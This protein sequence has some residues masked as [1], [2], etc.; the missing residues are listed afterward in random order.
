[1]YDKV[2]SYILL[3]GLFELVSLLL[4]HDCIE[5]KPKLQI[6][7]GVWKPYSWQISKGK[8]KGSKG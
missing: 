7:T 1:V 5:R 2:I 4:G 6:N 8:L 3:F